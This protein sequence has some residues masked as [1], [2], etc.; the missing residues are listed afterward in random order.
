[1]YIY[2]FNSLFQFSHLINRRDFSQFTSHF[3]NHKFIV[4]IKAS[5]F[6]FLHLFIS[7]FQISSENIRLKV[8]QEHVL[9][10]SLPRSTFST[11]FKVP[12]FVH[13]LHNSADMS[14][15]STSTSFF[16]TCHFLSLPAHPSPP[17]TPFFFHPF[18][19]VLL[20]P[21]VPSTPTS[22]QQPLS[23]SL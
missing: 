10:S 18:A 6:K 1:M 23:R 19:F 16:F 13:P 4:F 17:F 5:H 11:S 20:S 7:T 12:R 15:H 2:V 22:P 3:L 9:S 8:S 21:S 14:R